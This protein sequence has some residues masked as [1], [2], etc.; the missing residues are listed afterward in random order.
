MF[1]WVFFS[2][3]SEKNLAF[4]KIFWVELFSPKV[5]ANWN[6]TIFRLIVFVVVDWYDFC[7]VDVVDFCD[8]R[9]CNFGFGMGETGSAVS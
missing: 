4:M 6:K 1:F 8:F 7:L 3:C 5:L 2:T 9:L